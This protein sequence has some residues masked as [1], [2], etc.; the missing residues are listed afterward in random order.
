MKIA[1]GRKKKRILEN[2]NRVWQER[3]TPNYLRTVNLV[4]P[5]V[6]NTGQDF[7]FNPQYPTAGVSYFKK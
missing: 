1:G 5:V 6:P 4:A 7:N 3:G 2:K